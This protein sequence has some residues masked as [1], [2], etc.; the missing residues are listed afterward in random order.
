MKPELLNFCVRRMIRPANSDPRLVEA[1]TKRGSASRVYGRERRREAPSTSARTLRSRV[2]RESDQC[3]RP[4]NQSAIAP[5]RFDERIS[6]PDTQMTRPQNVPDM[7]KIFLYMAARP[8]RKDF[9]NACHE[10]D[11]AEDETCKQ[12]CPR[13]IRGFVVIHHRCLR[14]CLSF[15]VATIL[16]H[17]ELIK[18]GHNSRITISG[19]MR[20][21][22]F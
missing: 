20:L 13:E 15:L 18:C 11:Q 4:R 16:Q 21:P 12:E 2:R 7:K 3:F 22:Q 8:E 6:Q 9:V 5:P 17:T 14:R 1:S 19:L 10:E